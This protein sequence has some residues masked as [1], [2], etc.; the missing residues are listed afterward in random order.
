MARCFSSQ[1][2]ILEL[3]RIQNLHMDTNGWDDIGYSFL[4]GDDGMA[5]EARGWNRVGAH[6][7]GWNSKSVSIAV[8]GN[9]NE[10]L[11]SDEALNAIDSLISCGIS[12][13]NVLTNYTLY[14]H[15]AASKH[16]DSPGHKLNDLIQTWPHHANISA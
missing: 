9:F 5:Y 10:V 7:R 3:R 4:V 15:R 14:G 8:M 13:L 1:E 16:F 2:C 6:T 11:P 12:T